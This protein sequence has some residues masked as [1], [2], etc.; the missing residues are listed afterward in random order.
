M[1]FIL[2]SF[3]LQVLYNSEK[4]AWFDFHLVEKKPIGVY[5]ATNLLPLMTTS[6]DVDR[7]SEIG[8][9]ALK[10]LISEG[11]IKHNLEPNYYCE[12]KATSGC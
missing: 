4:G 2:I 5:Y 8:S 11:I 7:S 12:Y 9:K 3:P 6:Y 10:Y 1:L